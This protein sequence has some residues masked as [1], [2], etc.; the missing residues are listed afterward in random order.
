MK[1]AARYGWRMLGV[2]KDI[3]YEEVIGEGLIYDED[4]LTPSLAKGE[5]RYHKLDLSSTIAVYHRL[6]GNHYTR[7]EIVL[8]FD[9]LGA[10]APRSLPILFYGF[11][12]MLDIWEKLGAEEEDNSE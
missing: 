8:S 6:E 7:F 10:H 2:R 1:E 4:W 11:V 3:D 9:Y 12:N 5:Y